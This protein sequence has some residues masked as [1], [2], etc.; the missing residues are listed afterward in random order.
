MTWT[1]A[2]AEAKAFWAAAGCPPPFPRDLTPILPLALPVAVVVVPAL[3]LTRIEA[4]LASRGTPYRFPC[5]DRR[6]RGCLVAHAGA[7]LL[8]VD[9]AD[10]ADERRFTVAHEAAHMLVDYLRPREAAI[11]RFG[12]RIV[13]VLDGRRLLTRTDRIDAVLADC[14][15]GV[16]L[17][18]LDRNLETGAN[19][20]SVEERADLLACELLAPASEAARFRT[21]G[22]EELPILLRDA[23][24]FPLSRAAGYANRLLRVWQPAPSFVDWLRS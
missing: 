19:V 24:G 5:A 13:D 22:E 6:L 21:A 18:L 7:A 14:P 23:F 10:D 16:H 9:G 11:A 17:H 2:E 4:W 12:P 8:F 1:W 3:G 20:A 15:I